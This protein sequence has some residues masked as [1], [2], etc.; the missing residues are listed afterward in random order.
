[1]IKVIFSDYHSFTDSYEKTIEGNLP[2]GVNNISASYD[3]GR[4]CVII[5]GETLLDDLGAG[6]YSVSYQGVS[7]SVDRC[8]FYC[9]GKDFEFK[10]LSAGNDF[11]FTLEQI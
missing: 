4:G 3:G 10:D 2:E 8:R 1:M 6:D 5:D 9:Y 11:N 7:I